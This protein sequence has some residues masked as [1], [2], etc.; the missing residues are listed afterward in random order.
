MILRKGFLG[1]GTGREGM[2]GI[3]NR[4]ESTFDQSLR[5]VWLVRGL[6]LLNMEQ[7]EWLLDGLLLLISILLVSNV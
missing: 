2:V 1:D 3:E 5:T 4:V 6:A 7:L